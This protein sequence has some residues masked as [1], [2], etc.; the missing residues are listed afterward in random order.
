MKRSVLKRTGT[1]RLV[2]LLFALGA[3]APALP[4]AQTLEDELRLERSQRRGAVSALEPTRAEAP[5]SETMSF[6]AEMREVKLRVSA[7]VSAQY[8]ARAGR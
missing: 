2:A 3:L 6:E 5:A 1:K 7:F 8:R 4:L